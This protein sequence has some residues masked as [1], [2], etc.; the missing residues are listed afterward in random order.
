MVGTGINTTVMKPVER[1]VGGVLSGDMAQVRSGINLAKGMW[2]S[3]MYAFKMAAKAW[4]LGDNILDS[5]TARLDAPTHQLTYERI[6]NSLLKDRPDG[7]LTPRQEQ[8]ARAIG[9]LGTATRIPTRLLLTED[10]F[11]KQVAFRGQLTADLAE[12]ALTRGLKGKQ[13]DEYIAARMD[14]AFTVRGTPADNTLARRALDFSRDS[15]WTSELEKGSFGK[16][17]QSFASRPLHQDPHE[18]LPRCRPA[19]ASLPARAALPCRHT[20]RRGSPCRSPRQAGR[21]EH[22]DGLGRFGCP[23]RDHHG[24]AA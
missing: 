7:E 22:D 4:R 6:K 8:M 17:L 15:T 5:S 19:Y 12:E 10:E 14:D 2:G 3:S 21:G 24:Q 13:V 1:I 9:W 20:R 16:D 11:F 18:P 23:R